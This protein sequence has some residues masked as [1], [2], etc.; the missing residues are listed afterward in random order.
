[1]LERDDDHSGEVI[2][3]PCDADFVVLVEA[4]R[5]AEP[6][7]TLPVQNR[8]P[9]RGG[10][11]VARKQN[12]GAKV[13]G[14][15]PELRQDRALDLEPLDEVGVGRD[16]NRRNLVRGDE[17]DRLGRAVDVNTLRL[18]VEIAGRDV[19]VLPFPLVVVHPDGVAVG[20]RELGIDVDEALHVVVAGRQVLE[21][22]HG[23]AQVAG[24]DDACLTGR[25]LLHIATEERRAG[26]A[27]LQPRL[28]I[29]GPRNHDVN[30]AGDR[31]GANA[32]RKRYLYTKPTAGSRTSGLR[33]QTRRRDERYEAACDQ[34]FHAEILAFRRTRRNIQ[35]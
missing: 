25:Q 31:L 32:R 6:E 22:R 16:L 13:D 5:D 35:H 15:T 23:R 19:P 3:F 10:R 29:V 12:R 18:A 17:L 8:I 30:A 20:T 34:L 14:P 2:T 24:V 1:M 21:A 27:N 33:R 11:V 28:A 26:P 7:V 4:E 9:N